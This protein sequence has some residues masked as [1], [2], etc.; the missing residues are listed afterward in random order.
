MNTKNT[1]EKASA[2]AENAQHTPG[3]WKTGTPEAANSDV[4][5]GPWGAICHCDWTAIGAEDYANAKLIAAAPELL[6]ACKAARDMDD[7]QEQAQDLR[8]AIA[9]AEWGQP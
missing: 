9:R 4:V 7:D 1:T 5:Y 3:P 2:L 8:R 6:A